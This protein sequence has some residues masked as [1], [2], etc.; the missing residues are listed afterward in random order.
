MGH[1]KKPT[2]EEINQHDQFYMEAKTNRLEK[3]VD[4]HH[5]I[6]VSFKSPFYKEEEEK[7]REVKEYEENGPTWDFLEKQKRYS[8]F[9]KDKVKPKLS[10]KLKESMKEISDSRHHSMEVPDRT[11]IMSVGMSYLEYMRS[12]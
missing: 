5:T 3:T 12:L 2:L 9:V 1:R 4:L 10:R 7:F 8:Q 11:K 6:D